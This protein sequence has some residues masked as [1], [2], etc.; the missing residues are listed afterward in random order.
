MMGVT[1]DM[2]EM[3][4]WLGGNTLVRGDGAGV[5]VQMCNTTVTLLGLTLV[6]DG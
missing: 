3:R 4:V 6:Q 5:I 1:C 2:C